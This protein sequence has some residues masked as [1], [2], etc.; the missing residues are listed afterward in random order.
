MACPW[1]RPNGGSCSTSPTSCAA[2]GGTHWPRELRG[3]EPVL[4][5]AIGLVKGDVLLISESDRIAADMRLL[6]ESR[7]R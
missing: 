4:I 5:E 6:A 1:P 7:A 2:R 3:G